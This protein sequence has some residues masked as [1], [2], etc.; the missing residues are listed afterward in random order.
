M[1]RR[2]FIAVSAA[3]LLS[4]SSGCSTVDVVNSTLRLEQKISR[5]ERKT[6]QVGDH[7]VVYL[8][9]GQGPAMVML[10]GITGDSDNWVRF[11]RHYT[12][13]YRVILPD[14]PGFGESSRI[15]S[16]SYSIPAQSA[17]LVELMR[18]L[19]VKQFHLV[20][21]SMGGY[22]GAYYAAHHPQ[23]VLS[24][25]LFNAA[26]VDAPTQ[27]TF[28][29]ELQAGN[30]LMLPADR[31]DFNRILKMVMEDPPYIPGFARNV[32]ADKALKHREFNRKVFDELKQQQLDL[33]PFLP[34]ITSPTLLLWGERD[35]LIDVSSIPVFQRHLTSS[36]TTV[37]IL[38][39]IGHL[40]MLE[41]PAETARRY[42]EFLG[43]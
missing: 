26:G 36:K 15:N 33:A 17:R 20:G 39:K 8:E 10:H 2:L 43:L 5:L 37:S 25:G 9:G 24:L 18:L 38:P 28:M 29:K 13:R 40:P 7:E 19:G 21:N 4:L 41:Q 3:F 27:S 1:L 34:N 22:I 30:Y 14:L 12:D 42:N 6:I 11:A 35:Q 16:A 31:E 32:L 23:T